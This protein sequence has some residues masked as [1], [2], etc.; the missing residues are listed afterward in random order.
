MSDQWETNGDTKVIFW[1]ISTQLSPGY[2]LE[3]LTH[4]VRERV[5]SRL[6]NI[7][8][9]GYMIGCDVRKINGSIGL[10]YIQLYTGFRVYC[11]RCGLVSTYYV[12]WDL[13]NKDI[14][15]IPGYMIGRDV[16][17]INGSIVL[18]LLRYV[19]HTVVH[20]IQGLLWTLW[21]TLECTVYS[22]H[23]LRHRN[24]WPRHQENHQQYGAQLLYVQEVLTFLI[25][26]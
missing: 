1:L 2:I 18:M 3:V 26:S 22:V 25:I 9:L 12:E 14:K 13:P 23:A 15:N 24:D 8:I 10:R 20:W 17:R 19:H 21:I 5:I 11:E 6:R 4:M 7:V 16:W